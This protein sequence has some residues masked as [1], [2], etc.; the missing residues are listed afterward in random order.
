MALLDGKAALVTGGARGNGAG[1][2]RG[3]A[4]HGAD[5]VLADIDGDAASRTATEIADATDRQVSSIAGD[6]GDPDDAEAMVDHTVSKL[7]GIDILVNN[8]GILETADFLELSLESWERVLRVN[9][10]GSMLVAQAAARRMGDTNGGSIINV[11][12]IGAE[13]AFAGTTSYG[14]SKGGLQ[15]MTRTMAL[16]LARVG[17]RVNALAP[18]FIKTS[19]TEPLY[20]SE[21]AVAV[22]EEFVPLERMGVPAD[23]AGTVVY[24]ASDLAEYVTGETI[25]VDGGVVAGYASWRSG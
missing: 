25:T 19:M 12:S 6:V 8:A 7:G 13:A 18:G 16:D 17:I 5:V 14:A 24:L 2:G 15:M 23:L 22:I 3:L 9:L 11:T 20:T 10:T 4:D 21:K 1:I